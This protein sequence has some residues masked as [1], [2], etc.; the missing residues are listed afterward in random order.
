VKYLGSDIQQFWSEWPLGDD[1]YSDTSSEEEE[2][3]PS[4]LDP[5]GKYNLQEVFGA[6]LYQGDDRIPKPNLNGK[7]VGVEIQD[8]YNGHVTVYPLELEK[9][10]K[11]WL[12]SRDVKTQI[13]TVSVP[14]EDVPRF[15]ALLREQGFTDIRTSA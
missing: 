14:V 10:F 11:A 9:Y 3:D 1:W 4:S 2:I 6:I 7:S 12:K 5:K 8:A 13:F 15:L